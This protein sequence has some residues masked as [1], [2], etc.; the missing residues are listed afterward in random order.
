YYRKVVACIQVAD[1][2]YLNSWESV[3]WAESSRLTL[4]AP[5][6][7]MKAVAVFSRYAKR[8]AC[9]ARSAGTRGL[10]ACAPGWS[11]RNPDWDRLPGTEQKKRASK[12]LPAADKG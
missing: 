4:H 11:R 5:G 3:R 9:G 7:T 1:V 2:R 8:S 12:C 10:G 6:G